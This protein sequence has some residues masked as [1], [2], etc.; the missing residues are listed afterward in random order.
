MFEFVCSSLHTELAIRTDALK[1]CLLKENAS[2][3]YAASVATNRTPTVV[4]ELYFIDC[5]KI[6]YYSKLIHGSC[7]GSSEILAAEW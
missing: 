6:P 2:H 5:A 7:N 3:D 4:Q 1:P